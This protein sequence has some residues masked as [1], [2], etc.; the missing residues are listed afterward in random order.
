[1]EFVGV[2]LIVV[3]CYIVGEIYKALFKKHKEAYKYIPVFLSIIGEL[4]GII[5]HSTTP[6]SIFNADNIWMALSIGII[7]GA[8]STGANQIIKQLFRKVNEMKENEWTI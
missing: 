2:P 7:S 1:M 3:C 4:L 5:L 6:N 8:S